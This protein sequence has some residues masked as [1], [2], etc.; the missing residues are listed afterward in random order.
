MKRSIVDYSKLNEELLNLL[1]DKFP[2]GY[3]DTDIITFRNASNEVI[4]AVEVRTED[5]IYLVK[6][7]KRLVQAMEDYADDDYD[8]KDEDSNDEVDFDDAEQEETSEE[9]Y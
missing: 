6:V 1:V 4:E 5:T 8:D 3:N 2:D 7:G 9:D